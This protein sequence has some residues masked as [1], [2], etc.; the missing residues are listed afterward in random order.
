MFRKDVRATSVKTQPETAS[1]DA[2]TSQIKMTPFP[3]YE[4]TV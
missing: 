3:H 4:F 1:L 2:E